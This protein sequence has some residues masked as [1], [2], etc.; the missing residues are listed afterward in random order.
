MTREQIMALTG[1][2]LDKAVAV[3][4]G[5]LHA[6]E[7][8]WFAEKYSTNLNLCRRAEG[9]IARRG[10]LS[11]YG[12]FLYEVIEAPTEWPYMQ[13]MSVVRASAIDRCRAILLT[14]EAAK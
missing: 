2:D 8:K 14:L 6:G 4:I 10:L 5:E 1:R 12:N 3:A 7:V 11:E 9:V 13:V